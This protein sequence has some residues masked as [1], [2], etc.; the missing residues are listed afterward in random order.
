MKR[1]VSI[2]CVL[3][4][5]LSCGRSFK[6]S[7]VN[8][9]AAIVINPDTGTVLFESNADRRLPMASTTKIMTALLLCETANLDET[10][11][12]T[13][14]MVRVEGSSMGLLAGDTV[15][16]R[17]LLYGMLLPS[18]NDAA[19]TTAIALGGSIRDFVVIM[20]RRAAEIGMDNTNFVTPSGLDAE[21]HYT[22]AADMARLA[23]CAMKNEI[24]AKAACTESAVV[25]FGNPPYR[26]RL[27][28]H[29]KLLKNYSGANG[30]KTGYTKKSGRCL[31]SSACRGNKRLIAVT[32]NDSDTL[33]THTALLNNG[34][35][36]LDE[37]TLA[38]PD[39]RLSLPI[40]SGE[41][42]EVS[43]SSEEITLGLTAAERERLEYKISLPRFIYAPVAV[44]TTVGH[45][46]YSIGDTVIAE[47]AIKTATAVKL[48]QYDIGFFESLLNN[49]KMLISA[50]THFL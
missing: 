32:L 43:L 17:A 8:A 25:Q 11:T 34:F 27:Y 50:K 36:Q 31:V 22:T 23:A 5:I 3:C 13:D 12:V 45:I 47:L 38:L 35:A 7:A 37:V 16:Y 49:L 15:S 26:R 1:L 28:G 39:I 33:A 2:A 9:A 6:A 4:I 19:N 46:E 10:V 21:N 41:C 18:G 30:I 29:N 20:N 44:G 14:E 24:F 42:S 48:K 40:V